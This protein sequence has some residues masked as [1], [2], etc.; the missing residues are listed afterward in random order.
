MSAIHRHSGLDLLPLLGLLVAG[1]VVATL[2]L[3]TISI[4]WKQPL[5]DSIPWDY[6]FNNHCRKHLGEQL[7][8][9]KIY[10]LLKNGQCTMEDRYCREDDY[11]GSMMLWLCEDPVTGILGGL[12][13]VLETQEIMSGY[14]ES[15]E[16][17][18]DEVI[19]EEGWT[20][21]P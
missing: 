11:H 14:G 16:H 6:T 21:C 20:A 9:W 8:A 5:P 10:D 7:D 1:V 18:V 3:S 2:L 15:Y 12:F 19:D 17:W 4:S 13:V